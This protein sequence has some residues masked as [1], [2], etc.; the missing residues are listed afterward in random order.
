MSEYGFENVNM[1]EIDRIYNI[2]LTDSVFS[3]IMRMKLNHVFVNEMIFKLKQD[4]IKNSDVLR[5]SWEKQLRVIMRHVWCGGFGVSINMK[6]MRRLRF[7]ESVVSSCSDLNEIFDKIKKRYKYKQEVSE[8]ITDLNFTQPWA[9]IGAEPDDGLWKDE[10]KE[11]DECY[12]EA[13][14][15][16]RLIVYVKRDW[17]S[18]QKYVYFVPVETLN[19]R[20]MYVRIR[21]AFTLCDDTDF[22]VSRIAQLLPLMHLEQKARQCYEVSIASRAA[23]HVAFE[24]DSKPT[25]GFDMDEEIQNHMDSSRVEALPKVI[26]DGY[27][28][29]I[30]GLDVAVTTRRALKP[31]V[32]DQNAGVPLQSYNVPKGLKIAKHPEA[33]EPMYF[34]EITQMRWEDGFGLF[35]IPLGLLS[36]YNLYM[37]K[38]TGLLQNS[39]STYSVDSLH[40]KMFQDGNVRFSSMLTA[41]VSACIFYST[42]ERVLDKA[43]LKIAD[44]DE[45]QTFETAINHVDPSSD[46]VHVTMSMSIEIEKIISM[47]SSEIMKWDAGISIIAK[48]MHMD[49]EAFNK[50]RPRDLGQL[51]GIQEN[52]NES[53]PPAPKKKKTKSKK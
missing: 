15:V 16:S 34:K 44:I 20:T 35:E 6:E 14:N 31:Y 18:T 47:V 3:Q 51:V 41:Y 12:V 45:I 36:I 49:A 25:H 9:P 46:A 52:D 37:K 13:L 53:K 30:D 24:T 8:Y 10:V 29:E 11:E 43:A 1:S 4:V 33:H 5:E 2:G 32:P 42:S 22:T 7:I 19:R 28:R 38:D 48:K 39:G 50:K 21:N 26:R 23:P 27:Q 17:T 40:Y